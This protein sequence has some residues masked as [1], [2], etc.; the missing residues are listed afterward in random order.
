MSLV[1]IPRSPGDALTAPRHLKDFQRDWFNGLR[2]AM[3][4]NF[5]MQGYLYRTDDLW[6]IAGAHCREYW[7]KYHSAVMACFSSA[8]MSGREVIYHS[9]QVELIRTQL[10]KIR[11]ENTQLVHR[12]DDLQMSLF[13]GG[14]PVGGG[15]GGGRSP[16]STGSKFSFDFGFNTTNQ[17]PVSAREPERRAVERSHG[18]TQEDFDARDL[19]K[20]S[21]AIKECDKVIEMQPHLTEDDVVELACRRIGLPLKKAKEL[22]NSQRTSK[23]FAAAGD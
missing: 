10:A 22:L 13:S 11:T 21:A 18:Y 14:L 1:W 15:R 5:E 4:G 17:N 2:D 19:R 16:S 6:R 12:V 3:F 9:P 23:A 8:T 20:L 7:E